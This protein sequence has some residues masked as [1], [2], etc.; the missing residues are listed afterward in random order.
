[1][2]SAYRLTQFTFC[3]L[4]LCKRI[5]TALRCFDHSISTLLTHRYYSIKFWGHWVASA[6]REIRLVF[7]GGLGSTGDLG[8]AAM[9][10]R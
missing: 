5:S 8:M 9:A 6:P 4:E 10:K 1:M 2:T 3:S 7:S